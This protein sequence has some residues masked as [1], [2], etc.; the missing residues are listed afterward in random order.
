MTVGRKAQPDP[1]ISLLQQRLRKIMDEQGYRPAPLARAANLNEGAVRDI[2]R[3]RSNNPG[4][5]T[6]AK[7]ARVL[8]KRT[9]E[10]FEPEIEKG[11]AGTVLDDGKISDN[12]TTQTVLVPAA[13]PPLQAVI[14]SDFDV[15]V[16]E[17][18]R[19]EPYAFNCDAVIVERELRESPAELGRPHLIYRNGQKS[20]GLPII[21]GSTAKLEVLAINGRGRETIFEE[22]VFFSKTLGVV[23]ISGPDASD[24]NQ[25]RLGWRDG[26]VTS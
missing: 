13:S 2:I 19:L 14:F 1:V 23:T 21:G 12:K 22:E 16:V 11:I 25:S 8:G 24:Q 20:L 5:V 9:S 26:D 6:L 15:Y 4:I 3:G 10:L 18:D 7:I 17:T